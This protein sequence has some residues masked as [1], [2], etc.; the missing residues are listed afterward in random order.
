MTPIEKLKMLRD[1]AMNTVPD[2]GVTS[3][4]IHAYYSQIMVA[5]Q[6]EIAIVAHERWDDEKRSRKERSNEWLKGHGLG[7]LADLEPK[8]ESVIGQC[9]HAVD[10]ATKDAS[11]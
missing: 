8:P 1:V 4:D 7:D 6:I 2:R 11:N 5:A 10:K 3:S 9:E